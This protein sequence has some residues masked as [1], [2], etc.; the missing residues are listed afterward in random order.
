[1]G[2]VRQVGQAGQVGQVGKVGQVAEISQLSQGQ[3]SGAT[4]ASGR[5]Q[6]AVHKCMRTRLVA[7]AI[8]TGSMG[9]FR[10]QSTAVIAD[11]HFVFRLML[12]YAGICCPPVCC[13]LILEANSWVDS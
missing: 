2:Q 5:N 7:A 4:G 13:L 6:F 11:H 8:L 3:A 10:R 9:V 1:M 12:G